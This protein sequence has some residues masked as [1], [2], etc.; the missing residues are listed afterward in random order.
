MVIRAVSYMA[1]SD[2]FFRA[3]LER[4]TLSNVSSRLDIADVKG[5]AERQSLA[6][7]FGEMFVLFVLDIT[8][9]QGVD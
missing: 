9:S 6:L 3:S 8:H 5:G 2:S 1:R 7:V 4:M